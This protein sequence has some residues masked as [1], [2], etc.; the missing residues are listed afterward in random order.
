MSNIPGLNKPLFLERDLTGSGLLNL[1]SDEYHSVPSSQSTLIKPQ[2]GK[3]YKQGAHVYTLTR[4]GDLRE[5]AYKT[6]YVFVELDA[7]VSEITGL[8][9]YKAIHIKTTDHSGNLYLTYQAVGG[10]DQPDLTLAN[11]VTNTALTLNNAVNYSD[12]ENKPSKFNPSPHQHDIA[13]IYGF[14][15]IVQG[16]ED[17]RQNLIYSNSAQPGNVVA[18]KDV[19]IRQ[20]VVAAKNQIRAAT[21]GLSS[22]LSAHITGS[23]N[24]HAYT[25]AMVG[26]GNVSNY[27]FTPITGPGGIP[28][29]VYASPSTISSAITNKPTKTNYAH[30]T[31]T[32]N[33]HVDTA[34]SVGLGNVA[35]Y[36][37]YEAYP[38]GW[39]NTI[40]MNP[41][42]PAYLSPDTLTKSLADA[43][44][45]QYQLNFDPQYNACMNP[46]NGTVTLLSA[47]V[48]AANVQLST[49]NTAITSATNAVTS[50]NNSVQIAA[51]ANIAF[52][53]KDYNAPLASALKQLLAFDY[54]RHA[55]GYSVG[56]DGL[57]PLP[58]SIDNLY[59]WLDADYAGNTI[60]T[61]GAV[62]RVT[63]VLDRSSYQR[64]FVSNTRSAAPRLQPSQ[65]IDAGQIGITSGNVI[66]FNP[67]E[68]LDQISGHAVTLKPGMTIFALVRSG[69]AGTRLV[70]L[71]DG[72]AALSNSIVVQGSQQRVLDIRTDI[73]W[74]P[75]TAPI[76]TISG[77]KSQLV[78]ASIDPYAESNC[79]LASA[80]TYDAAYP[81]GVN[82]PASVWPTQDTQTKALFR[83]GSADPLGTDGGEIAALLIYNRRL[84]I[85][86]AEAVVAYLRLTKSANQAFSVDFSIRNAI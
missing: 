85:A 23:S 79:W 48:N 25:A 31:Q 35:N 26:L 75:L 60:E 81:R 54:A 16:L 14:D 66:K 38:P 65:D 74:K 17:L 82:T 21:Q 15:Y 37:I 28:L 56:K 63:S 64:L 61:D 83:I 53:L 68:Y 4:T 50:A 71:S 30:A 7:P 39:Y 22:L 84:S 24:P 40:L 12:I 49:A 43:Q 77:N 67:G 72:S 2:Y 70:L 5:L 57:W 52:E 44:S 58:P 29:P 47:Q 86:E 42:F 18:Y 19:T 73:N 1:V 10:S 20:K 32:N 76:N 59:L 69:N 27:G 3:F 8:E 80:R 9:V 13:D 78:V 46:T 41:T 62:R 34:A 55:D 33:P 11:S 6:E 51:T 45:N 36:P